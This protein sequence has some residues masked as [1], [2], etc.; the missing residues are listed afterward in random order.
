MQGEQLARARHEKLLALRSYKAAEEALAATQEELPALRIA[1][2][3]SAKE[4][5]EAQAALAEAVSSKEELRRQVDVRIAAFIKVGRV[6]VA[7]GVS[8]AAAS[9]HT[10]SARPQACTCAHLHAR[11]R[12]C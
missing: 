6:V 11:G 3:L 12:P 10:T 4:K 5:G 8:C 2:D 1:R 9:T 7:F